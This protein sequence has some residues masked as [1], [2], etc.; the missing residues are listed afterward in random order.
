MAFS[1]HIVVPLPVHRSRL[2][3]SHASRDI[4]LT[5][6]ANVTSHSNARPET[7]LST[8]RSPGPSCTPADREVVVSEGEDGGD[9]PNKIPEE[10]VE[11]VVAEVGVAG[12]GDVDARKE[13]DDCKDEQINWRCCCLVAC[14]GYDSSL[15]IAR[16]LEWVVGGCWAFVSI[17]SG[18]VALERQPCRSGG[19]GRQLGC[20]S[21]VGS[22][23]EEGNGDG[24]FG[25]EEE[26]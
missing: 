3:I 13:R 16:G 7:P 22:G 17:I 4:S 21:A 11:A 14:S 9:S 5:W 24:E 8:S 18:S 2:Q 20:L 15:A 6:T 19:E 26:A 23:G 10:D 12:R 25:G 1:T